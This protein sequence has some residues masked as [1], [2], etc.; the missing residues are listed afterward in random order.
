MF[1][2]RSPRCICL[3]ESNV[4]YRIAVIP[5]IRYSRLRGEDV[6]RSPTREQRMKYTMIE[7]WKRLGDH[8]GRGEDD[9]GEGL[10]GSAGWRGLR[11]AGSSVPC[12]ADQPGCGFEHH[13]LSGP[14]VRERLP[15]G[16]ENLV[17]LLAI[18]PGEESGEVRRRQ[19]MPQCVLG[20]VSAPD[21]FDERLELDAGV[22]RLGEQGN[23]S[24]GVGESERT[25]RSRRRER[26]QVTGAAQGS[27]DL[28]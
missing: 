12:R 22:A 11:C 14:M 19:V 4:R 23:G 17:L 10:D 6:G 1:S 3:L 25:R 8:N 27:T 24:I 2:R 13:A 28:H 26:R 15:Q 7:A 18:E 5:V 20:I 9:L 21:R 16:T